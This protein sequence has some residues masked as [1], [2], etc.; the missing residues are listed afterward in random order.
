MVYRLQPDE[1]AYSRSKQRVKLMKSTY[2]NNLRKKGRNRK[3]KMV[4]HT[5]VQLPYKHSKQDK[6]PTVVRPVMQ[7]KS[8]I[9]QGKPANWTV[10]VLMVVVVGAKREESD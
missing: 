9:G 5:P 6:L 3:K 10:M 7:P 2:L 4:K 1:T 8:N